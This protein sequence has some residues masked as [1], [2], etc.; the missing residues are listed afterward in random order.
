[1]AGDLE[2]LK[3][4]GKRARGKGGNVAHGS[5]HANGRSENR[6]PLAR[7]RKLDW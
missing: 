5:E 3:P 7:R 4:T 1:V 6:G 2:Y